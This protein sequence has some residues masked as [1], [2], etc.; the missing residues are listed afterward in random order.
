M[1]DKNQFKGINN[2]DSILS[3]LKVMD[4]K[5]V[6]SLLV[7]DNDNFISM[8][9]IGDIQ[10]AIINNV[11]LAESI[12]KII[13]FN[14]VYVDENESIDSIKNKMISM[15]AESMPVLNEKGDLVN[16]IFWNDIF[17][18]AIENNREKLD[19]PV[20][21]MAGG[22]GTRL[23]PLTNVIPKP[24]IPIN[25]KTILELIIEKFQ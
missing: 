13:D 2:S 20:I 12:E 9:T 6:K 17:D 22:K 8:L 4:E 18:G 11:S 7:F 10:R 24:L 21:I 15:R 14:K 16:V 5:S 25:E 1:L 19:L 23:K 3:A